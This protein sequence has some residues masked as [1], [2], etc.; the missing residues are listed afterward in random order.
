MIERIEVLQGG[1]SAIYGSDAIAGVV[2]IITRRSQD[3]FAASA[4]LGTFGEGDGFSQNYSLSWGIGNADSTTR[5][6]VGGNYVKQDEVSSADR[7]ISL[8]P[9]PGR[10]PPATAPAARARPMA[11]SS[12]SART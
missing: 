7:D 12:C 6:V 2:N 8:F 1:A 9:T 4:Q 3:G 11:A 5:F 10:R